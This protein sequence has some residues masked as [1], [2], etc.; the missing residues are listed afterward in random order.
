MPSLADFMESLN[1]EQDKLVHMGTIKS[2]K[3]QYL[4]VGVLNPSKG[5]KKSKESKQQ[6]KKKQERP[7]P[8]DGGLIPCEDKDKKKK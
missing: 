3:D 6:D 2:S 4:V 5:K 7:K 8:S 1:Q